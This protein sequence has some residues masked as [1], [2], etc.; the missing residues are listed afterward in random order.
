MERYVTTPSIISNKIRTF[1]SEINPQ[2]DPFYVSCNPHPEALPSECF[3]NVKLLVQEIGGKMLCGWAIWQRANVLIE[4]EAH[5]IWETPNG[6]LLDVTPHSR[7]EPEILFLIDESME[8]RGQIIRNKRRPLTN[9]P[10]VKEFIALFEQRE[11]IIIQSEG[12]LI[13]MPADL[14]RRMIEIERQLL[15]PAKRNDPCPCM[16]GLKF[17]KCCGQ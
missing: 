13:T 14:M 1:C 8:Y 3:P 11:T 15:A 17:K 6:S 9:S 12:P 2:N 4:A 10:L 5:A 16:S 7:N